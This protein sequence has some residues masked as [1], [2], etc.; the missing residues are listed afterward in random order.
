MYYCP[1][2]CYETTVTAAGTDATPTGDVANPT[3]DSAPADN[4]AAAD[5]EQNVDEGL[6]VVQ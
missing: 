2:K 4:A 5:A 3:T 1:D 6:D